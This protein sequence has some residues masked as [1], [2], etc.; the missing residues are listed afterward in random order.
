MGCTLRLFRGSLVLPETLE[1]FSA[2]QRN[3]LTQDTWFLFESPQTSETESN[4]P[5]SLRQEWFHNLHE[6]FLM[7][8]SRKTQW[9]KEN[10]KTDMH[11]VFM[12]F[13]RQIMEGCD[14]LTSQ[15]V[16]QFLFVLFEDKTL[17]SPAKPWRRTA[18]FVH[19][20]ETFFN[21][22]FVQKI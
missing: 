21:R 5:R 9:E 22:S 16:L 15:E 14:V 11:S 12:Q 6:L 7:I 13:S 10:D 2:L 20:T 18:L 1:K 17:K 19:K 8:Y 3:L 4:P